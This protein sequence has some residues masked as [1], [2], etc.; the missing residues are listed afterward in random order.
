MTRKSDI[1]KNF[2]D[3][4]TVR[5]LNWIAMP[6]ETERLTLKIR[7]CPTL[8]PATVTAVEGGRLA[9]KMDC[10]DAGVASGQFA[11][12]YDGEICLGG[13]CIE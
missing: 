9:V 2:R 7:H 3:S 13:G 12:F 4:F 11:V 1:E 10:P 8:T 6:P 5:A